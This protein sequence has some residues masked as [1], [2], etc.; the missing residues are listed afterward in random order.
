MRAVHRERGLRR[1]S[2]SRFAAVYPYDVYDA[3][4]ERIAASAGYTLGFTENHGNAAESSSLLEIHR[5]SISVPER[6]AEAL[7][8]VAAGR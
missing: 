7:A 8:A 1:P 3:R 5:Y 6:F 4:V 2:A